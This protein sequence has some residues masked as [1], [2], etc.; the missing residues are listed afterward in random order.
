MHQEEQGRPRS[1]RRRDL[2]AAA[3]Q[4]LATA[5][6]EGLRTRDV[7]ADAGVNI[8]TLHYYFPTKEAL[9][10]GVIGHATQRFTATL[11][12]SGAAVDRLRSHLEALAGLLK[13]D[14]QLWAVM[15]ELALR[16]ARDAELAAILQQTEA[17]WHHTLEELIE[18]S[19]TERTIH[20]LL[21]PD[22]MAALMILAIKG[23]SMPTLAGV[24]PELVDQMFWEFE[25]LLGLPPADA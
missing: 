25:W 15:G 6:F 24:R 14:H 7:A 13:T 18:R 22:R 23:L 10:R 16:S 21:L 11:P 5:G 17:Y 4:R 3:F 20:P 9:I 8:A 2:V 19:L 12:S 1:D